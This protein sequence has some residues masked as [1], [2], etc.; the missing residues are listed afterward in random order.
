L[1]ERRKPTERLLKMSRP[2]SERYSTLFLDCPPGIS[3]L[4]ENVLRAA[5]AVVVPLLP[6]PLSVRM[7]SQLKDFIQKQGWKDI[8]LL[9]FFSMVDRRKSLHKD[10]IENVRQQFPEILT[11]EIPYSSVIERMTL[12]RAPLPAYSPGSD[13]GRAYAALWNEILART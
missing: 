6:T 2:L 9:P 5:D 4:S 11:T 7:L 13:E 1:S 3:L 10:V 8:A 12:R